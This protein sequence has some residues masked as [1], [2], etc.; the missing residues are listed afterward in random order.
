MEKLKARFY[1]WGAA[2]FGW[3]AKI[4][5]GYWRPRIVVISGSSGKTTLFSLLEAQLGEMAEFPHD[6]NSA[7]G[8]AFA[9]LKL[10]RR[11][12]SVWEWLKFFI[13][14]PF[15][16][17]AGKGRA[18]ILMIEADAERP[19][20]AKFAR[21]LLH[22]E[23]AVLTNVTHTHASW[24]D[25]LVQKGQ[26]ENVQDAI[27][28][29]F[30]QI[31]VGAETAIINADNQTIVQAIERNDWLREHKDNIMYLQAADYLRGYQIFEDRTQFVINRETYV[32]PYF[33]PENIAFSLQVVQIL[34]SELGKRVDVHFA[35]YQ[36]PPGRSTILPGIRGTRLIDSTY[37]ANLDS[38]TAMLRAYEQY[39]VAKKWLVLG[40]FREQ[41]VEAKQ[42]HEELAKRLLSLKTIEKV[43]LV[44]PEMRVWVAPRLLQFWPR[45][46]LEQFDSAGGAYAWL[47][48]N[49]RGGETILLKGS[50]GRHL[51]AIVE[52]LLANKEDVERLACRNAIYRP[53]QEDILAAGK[54]II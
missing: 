24:Y 39:P 40:E 20:E 41:G 29:E 26:Y 16:I 46:M 38:T 48:K 15:C 12:Y 49:I 43:I 42:Q 6:V 13:L 21:W 18:K 2:W 25:N 27:V 8:L 23:I 17:L 30:V 9:I 3:W 4:V 32:F 50:Q 5:L 53:V 35:K 47:L 33:L 34:C 28:D 51:E 52:G 10:K 14:A 11:T 19:G 36:L 54:G 7:Y 1:F 31:L 45:E 37:N 22:P 44:S